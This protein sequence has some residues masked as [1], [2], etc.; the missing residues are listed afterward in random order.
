LSQVIIPSNDSDRVVRPTDEIVIV[1][2]DEDFRRILRQILSLEGLTVTCYADGETFLKQASDR[3]P[4]C[5]FLD[6]VLPGR[7]GIEVLRELRELR[8]KAPVF[9]ISAKD[10]TP[11]VVQGIKYGANDFLRKPFDPY[12]A[13]SRVRDAVDLWGTSSEK[14]ADPENA[15]RNVPSNIRLTRREEE[16]LAQVIRGVS[17]RDI[18]KSL[19][20]AKRTIDF[21]RMSILRKLGARN[22]PDLVRIVKSWD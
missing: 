14:P 10:D 6:V 13:V 20:V 11:T 9:L 12:L 17:S 21:F 2:D 18:S 7:S 16:V 22:T 19:G 3:I 5:V 8:F 4:V 1:D 15:A